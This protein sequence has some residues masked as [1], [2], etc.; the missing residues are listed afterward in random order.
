MLH[1][2]LYD[3]GKDGGKPGKKP[4]PDSEKEQAEEWHKEL[5]EAIA[6]NDEGLMEKYFE[7]GELTEDEMKQGLKQAMI[8][9]DIF[10][11]F[12]CSATQNMGSGR[13]MG[14]IDHVCPSANEMPPQVLRN[15][16]KLPGKP[17][18]TVMNPLVNYPFLKFTAAP[19][20]AEWNW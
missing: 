17:M 9:H 16:S 15:G 8:N 19:L 7:Q 4:I 11:L 12:C 20:R 3:F 13:L 18:P 5:V 2:V 14:F 10:P 1:M 6:G